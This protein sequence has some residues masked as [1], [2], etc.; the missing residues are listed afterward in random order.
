M[1]FRKSQTGVLK[2]VAQKTLLAHLCGLSQV[3]STQYSLIQ[4]SGVLHYLS[5]AHS[6]PPISTIMLHNGLFQ[7]TV[8]AQ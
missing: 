5:S 4:G 6:N 1:Q 7:R 8:S 2:H 3:L